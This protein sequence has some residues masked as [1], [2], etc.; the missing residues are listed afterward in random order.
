MDCGVVAAPSQWIA[1]RV[2][3]FPTK[4]FNKGSLI[5]TGTSE[6]G[7]WMPVE[8]NTN[9]TISNAAHQ[10]AATSRDSRVVLVLEL[11]R[12]FRSSQTCILVGQPQHDVWAVMQVTTTDSQV[13]PTVRAEIQTGDMGNE[14]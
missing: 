10:A 1:G 6:L 3:L 12:L 11:T 4:K 7:F 13:K 2:G 14:C 9:A 5:C 8:D